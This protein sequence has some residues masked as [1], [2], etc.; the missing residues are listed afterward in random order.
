MNLYFVHSWN[1]LGNVIINFFII[2]SVL[3]LQELCCRTIVSRTTGYGIDQL[4]LPELIKS[5]L[6]SYALTSASPH[7]MTLPRNSQTKKGSRHGSSGQIRALHPSSPQNGSH[8]T[9]CT[10]RNSCQIS[11]PL[12]IFVLF[13]EIFVRVNRFTL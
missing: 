1:T 6:K 9:N 11:W 5:H 10:G 13:N 4:P 12:C 2:F 3:S 8:D 7:T